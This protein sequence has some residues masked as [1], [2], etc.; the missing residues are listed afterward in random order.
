[1]ELQLPKDDMTTRREWL[2]KR[3]CSLTPRQTMW[4]F[5]VLCALS[6]GVALAFLLLL[7]TWI[8]V[9]FAIV[10]MAGV[11]AAFLHYARHAVD[12]EHIALADGCLLVEQF[13]AGT[14]RQTRLDPCWIR[15]IPPRH[16]SDMI[17]LEARGVR[18][19]I[20]R[21]ATEPQRCRMALELR[22][23]LRG[24]SLVS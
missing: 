1:M 16:G 18:V 24:R 21:F 2:L 5:A 8:V 17:T 6:F 11:G 14:V 10:E 3:N 12:C 7:G 9:V 20:G 13:S 19:E 15:V 22:Q 23:G 4:A